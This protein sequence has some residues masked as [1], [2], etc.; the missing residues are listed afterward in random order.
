VV[1]DHDGG[2]H[3]F[4]DLAALATCGTLSVYDSSYLELALRRKLPLVCRDGALRAAAVRH[5]IPIQP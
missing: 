2:A 1:V 3:A 4:G 5:R